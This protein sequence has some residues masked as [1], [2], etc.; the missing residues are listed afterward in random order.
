MSLV[1]GCEMLSVQPREP[2]PDWV[3][4]AGVMTPPG[5]CLDTCRHGVA[6]AGVP[7]SNDHLELASFCY[8]FI[9]LWNTQDSSLI[10]LGGLLGGDQPLPSVAP[11]GVVLAAAFA[12]EA[13]AAGDLG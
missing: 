4:N 10:Q 8:I 6:G 13:A 9:L 5:C 1:P 12:G 2:L 3:T 11:P 7:D